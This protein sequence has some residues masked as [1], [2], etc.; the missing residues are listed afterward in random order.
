VA[1]TSPGSL[2]SVLVVA[3]PGG[4]GT[5]SL[6]REARRMASHSPVPISVA[7]VSPSAGLWAAPA[8]VGRS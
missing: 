8:G 5:A 3:F 7:E 6:V 4:P 1:H 2:A